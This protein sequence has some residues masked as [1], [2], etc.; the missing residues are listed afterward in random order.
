MHEGVAISFLVK[1]KGK[2]FLDTRDNTLVENLNVINNE[3]QIELSAHE[4]EV[5][6]YYKDRGLFQEPQ[7]LNIPK[8]MVESK[9]KK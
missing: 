6:R 7:N 1:R 8:E 4:Q 2:M 9:H 5:L 3:N